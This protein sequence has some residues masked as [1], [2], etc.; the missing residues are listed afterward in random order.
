MD[1]REKKGNQEEED[2]EE[3]YHPDQMGMKMKDRYES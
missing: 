2:E 1:K 3:T